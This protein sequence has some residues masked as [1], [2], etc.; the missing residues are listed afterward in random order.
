MSSPHHVNRYAMSLH[1]L[2]QGEEAIKVLQAYE[3]TQD[4]FDKSGNP[5][6]EHSELVLYQ[7]TIYSES[8]NHAVNERMKERNRKP[9]RR[10]ILTDRY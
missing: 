9:R 1:L 6:Y 2:G 5:D 4:D 8:G 10:K 7:A 3:K